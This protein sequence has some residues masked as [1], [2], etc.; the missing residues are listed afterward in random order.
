M[1][2]DV[3]VKETVYGRDHNGKRL[4]PQVFEGGSW[5]AL[6]GT[7]FAFARP[8]IKSLASH[9][10]EP[11]EWSVSA[12]QPRI[13]DFDT[14]LTI[15]LGR[16]HFKPS[17]CV[18]AQQYLSDHVNNTFTVAIFKWGNQINSA[19]DLQEFNQQCVAPQMQD[20]AGAAAEALHQQTVQTLKAEWSPFY[21][22]YET[23][24]RMWASFILKKPTCE[25]ESLVI[26]H[27]PA[28]MIHLFES[29]AS[30][31]QARNEHLQQR[32]M[33]AHDVVDACLEDLHVFHRECSSLALRIQSCITAMGTKKS[34]IDSFD[35]QVQPLHP[36]EGLADLLEAIPNINDTEHDETTP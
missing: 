10:S 8:H 28:T 21:K 4:Q 19:A 18:H 2:A 27:P 9:V 5:E 11:R 6:K 25:L 33:L 3:V 1:R 23:T 16:N 20:R 31:A 34:M 29:V 36:G 35:R 13:G 15:K 22:A 17:S 12:E 24:W 26:R 14:F 7:I 30:G 32:L